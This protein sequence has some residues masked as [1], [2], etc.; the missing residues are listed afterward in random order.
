MSSRTAAGSR[1]TSKT[2]AEWRPFIDAAKKA[3]ALPEQ[4]ALSD[5]TQEAFVPASPA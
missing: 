3:L 4:H 1:A 5:F 2:E